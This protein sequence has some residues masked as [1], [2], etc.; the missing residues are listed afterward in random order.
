MV[1]G[2]GLCLG[3]Q[4]IHRRMAEVFMSLA[5]VIEYIV[6]GDPDRLGGGERCDKDRLR[7]KLD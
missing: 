2:A 6:A 7:P 5:A 3:T 1:F 4:A